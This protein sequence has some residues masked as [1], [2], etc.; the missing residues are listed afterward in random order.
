MEA[1]V[2]FTMIQRPIFKLSILLLRM[3]KDFHLE[4]FSDM[5]YWRRNGEQK[6]KMNITETIEKQTVALGQRSLLVKQVRRWGDLNTDAILDSACQIFSIPTIEGFIGYKIEGECAIVF[7]E[8]L[9][10]SDDKGR[11]AEA[12][13]RYCEGQNLSVTYIIVSDEFVNVAK[14]PIAIQFGNKLILDP[15][16]DPLKNTG[17]KGV[18]VR[19]KV[20]RAI[21]EGLSVSEYRSD[22]PKLEKAIEKIGIAW[23]QSRHGA[24]VYIAH[25]SFFADKEGK[26]WFYAHQGEKVVGV[27]LLNQIQASSGWLLNNLMISKEAPNGTSELLITSV[28]KI[29]E[30]E[31][32]HYVEIGPV[33]GKQ[34]EKLVGLGPFSIWLTRGL[35]K[36][37]KRIFRLDGQTDFWEKFQPEKEP[38]YLLFDQINFRTI[39]ALK[40]ALNIRF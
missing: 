29:L 5:S 25:L 22:D 33:V 36:V 23:L 38:S 18:L 24:Q 40:S 16:R 6:V 27:L 26:R 15:S 21:G 10:A 19:K 34:L 39:K 12:F 8:P 31:K 7:G 20:K 1:I 2:P 9:C 13:Q 32:C 30:E 4:P 11:L 28:L 14:K 35:F 37:A 3:L 17:S